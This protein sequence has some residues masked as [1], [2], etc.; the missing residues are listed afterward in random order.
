M[1]HIGGVL[2]LFPNETHAGVVIF[3]A[4]FRH[5]MAMHQPAAEGT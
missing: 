5:D 3:T 1:K 4:F 2:A